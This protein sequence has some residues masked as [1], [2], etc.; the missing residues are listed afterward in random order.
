[1]KAI[2]YLFVGAALLGMSSPIMAQVDQASAITELTKVVKSSA[3]AKLKESQ[4]KDLLKPFKKDPKVLTAVGR[5][6]LDAKDTEK[7]IS[8]ADMAIAREKS[9]GD[10]YVLKGDVA[11]SLD[12]GGE[13][14]MWFEQAIL[15]EPTNPNG[16]RR[17]AQV[18]SKVNPAGSV[19]KLEELRAAV[20]GYPVDII[21]AEIYDKSGNLDKAIEYYSKV[22]YD[23]MEDYQLANYGTDLFLKGKFEKSLEVANYGA[24]KFPRNAGMNRLAFFN[25]T[26]LK[27]YEAALT[28]A[29]KLFNASDSAKISEHDYLYLGY[30]NLGAE[31]YQEAVDAFNKCLETASDDSSNRLDAYKNLAEAYQAKGDFE[32]GVASYKKY[33]ELKKDRTANDYNTLAQMYVTESEKA[34]GEA[35]TKLIKEA[36][37]VYADMVEKFPS[38]ADFSTVQRAHLAFTLDPDSKEGLAKPHYEKLVE[39]IKAKTEKGDRDDARLVEAYRYLGA[40]YLITLDDANSANVYWKKILEIDP[41]NATAKQALGIQ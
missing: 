20:P 16:Y 17:Y 2:K 33:L 25:N 12:N 37:A 38:V 41:E 36:D 8:Y 1:M 27:N 23:K 6:Y 14:S 10:A 26:N 35:K 30:A 32:G 9:Y 18:N 19:A 21:S 39:I 3:D 4:V 11:A 15:A 24:S 7:A 22:S 29:D 31:K 28:A 5:A 13:A 40:Y 34:E